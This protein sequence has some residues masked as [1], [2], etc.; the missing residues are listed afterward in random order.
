MCSAALRSPHPPAPLRV[1]RPR[2][3]GHRK[4]GVVSADRR[5]VSNAMERR[6]FVAVAAA[7]LAG[8]VLACAGPA[9]ADADGDG[10]LLNAVV[11]AG[12]P[13]ALAVTQDRRGAARW[14]AAGVA[15]RGTG[16]K[17]G[18]G[19]RYR[20][21]SITKTFVAVVVL[22]LVAEGRCGL[23]DPADRHLPGL[24]TGGVSGEAAEAVTVRHLLQHTSGLPDYHLYDGLDS[25]A[26]FEARRF[27]DPTPRTSI[28][29]ALGHPL[30]FTP[31]TSWSYADTN[32]LV[33]GL[34]AER[35][36]GRHV[37][38][39]VT[40]RVL[41]PLGLDATSYPVHNPAVT[42]R[43]L[44][45]YVPSDAPGAPFG[46]PANLVDFTVE[47]VD[48]TGAAGAIISNGPDL[49]RFHRALLTGRL[50][51]A[52]L[53]AE[54]LHSVPTGASSGMTGYGLGVE[55]WDLGDGDVMW[56]N[57]GSIRGYTS[58]LLGNGD[59]SAQ[60]A[61]VFTLNPT[62][63]VVTQALIRAAGGIAAGLNPS[64]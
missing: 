46:D 55:A 62:P 25:A 1:G 4:L 58:V 21:A 18:P 34:L 43:H 33:L 61:A 39:Q 8:S 36:T 52:S 16:R 45:G 59:G 22:Q 12:A 54:M 41:R 6:G 50:L 42:G 24:L 29:L 40:D 63:P 38:A 11:E 7:G 17:P 10:A 51:P 35:L 57:T 14:A 53:T 30:L 3:R 60:M 44:H 64:R 9:A 5:L 49:L 56:G 23:D 37:S 27:E 31:G 32:Y 2:K 48:Q 20:V 28:A 13:G 47:T 15:E 19:D 26:A